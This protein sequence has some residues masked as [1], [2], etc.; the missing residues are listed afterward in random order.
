VL[1][2]TCERC[3]APGQSAAQTTR[4][5]SNGSNRVIDRNADERAIGFTE[6]FGGGE[7]VRPHGRLSGA[8]GAERKGA[9]TT[10]VVPAKAGP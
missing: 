1:H 9:H 10:I 8:G 5:D 3:A 7:I 6:V 2:S 4:R